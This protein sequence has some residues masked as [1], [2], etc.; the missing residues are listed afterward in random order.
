MLEIKQVSEKEQK[1]VDWSEE[2]NSFID[3]AKQ[4]RHSDGRQDKLDEMGRNVSRLWGAFK[5]EENRKDEKAL[6]KWILIGGV[7]LVVFVFIMMNADL[8]CDVE[9]QDARAE[10]T[11]VA[12][13]ETARTACEGEFTDWRE[14]EENIKNATRF[15]S[16]FKWVN[17]SLGQVGHYYQCA[18]NVRPYHVYRAQFEV[19]NTFGVPELHDVV[20]H[21]Y[22]EDGLYEIR[23]FNGVTGIGVVGN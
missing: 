19:S 6:L 22:P 3:D 23:A 8:S 11:A 15:P 13:E 9:C 2:A 20:V 12:R 18:D 4:L 21:L 14:V 17:K 7:V 1:P 16:T 10:R 5:Q